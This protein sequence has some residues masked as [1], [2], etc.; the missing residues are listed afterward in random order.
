MDMGH[1][2][3]VEQYGT[4]FPVI[5]TYCRNEKRE[6]KRVGVLIADE[7]RNMAPFQFLL[8]TI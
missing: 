7:N 3:S 6:K 1:S 4:A 2:H 5:M 8:S